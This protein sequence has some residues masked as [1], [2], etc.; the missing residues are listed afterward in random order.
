MFIDRFEV[1]FPEAG[2]HAR[3]GLAP[4]APR[5]IGE[6]V[7]IDENAK[8]PKSRRRLVLQAE[9]LGFDP[10]ILHVVSGFEERLVTV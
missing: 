8:E 9:G 6:E 3:P 2:V 5:S 7:G 4:K 1:R 10:P